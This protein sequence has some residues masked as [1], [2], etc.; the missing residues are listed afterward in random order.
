MID[1][2]DYEPRPTSYLREYQHTGVTNL[3]DKIVSGLLRII[4]MLPTGGG[5]TVMFCHMVAAFIRRRQQNVV[6]F[7]HREELLKQARQTMYHRENVIAEIVK[8]GVRHWPPGRVHVCMVETAYNRLKKN[9]TWFKNV[10]MVIIDECHLDNFSKT[11]PFFDNV[12]VIGFSASPISSNKRKPLKDFY[13]DIVVC[14]QI[15]QLIEVWQADHTQ[16]LVPNVTFNA[17]SVHREELKAANN[18]DGFDAE[19]MAATYSVGKHV[20][21]TVKAYEEFSIGKK[22]LIFNCNKDHSKL[23]HQ[24]F[25]DAGYNSRHLDSDAPEHIRE[26]TLR[27]FKVTDD[28][29]LNNIGILTTGFDEPSI[30]GIIVNKA[31]MSVQLWLQMCG[32]GGR[33]YPGKELFTIVDMGGNCRI[34]GDWNEWRDWEKMFHHPELPPEGGIGGVKECSHCHALIPVSSRTCKW[35]DTELIVTKDQVYDQANLEF[36][37]F[38]KKLPPNINVAQIMEDNKHAKAFYSLHQ[39]KHAL[40]RHYNVET[41]TDEIAYAM[42]ALYQDKVEE[43]CKLSKKNY[44][45]FMKEKS[46]LWL[47]DELKNVYSWSAPTFEISF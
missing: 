16:G 44:D 31:T 4:C 40:I 2:P 17:K 3:A 8:A 5:K 21:N 46:A 24:A 25:V 28:A 14:T 35:C 45:Q 26:D 12:I 38:T 19:A 36:K 47:M 33:P 20:E 39:I 13:Q 32:R 18:I 10:G 41:M 7:V 30:R 6:I 11:F 42:L 23:V 22:T 34:H 27:W 43:W 15:P 37:L 9:P 1:L 29:I